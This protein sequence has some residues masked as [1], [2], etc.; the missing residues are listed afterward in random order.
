[1][2]TRTF[3]IIINLFTKGN[4]ELLKKIEKAWDSVGEETITSVFITDLKILFVD[5]FEEICECIYDDFSTFISS[6]S[7]INHPSENVE[8]KELDSL[9]SDLRTF[10]RKNLIINLNLHDRR[11]EG[12]KSKADFGLSFQFPVLKYDGNNFSFITY[13]K[14]MLLQCK[15]NSDKAIN[16]FGEIDFSTLKKYSINNIKNYF[17]LLFYNFEYK[18]KNKLKLK[19][20][21]YIPISRELKDEDF[22]NEI[23][24]YLRKEKNECCKDSELFMRDFINDK[25]GTKND[26]EFDFFAKID[27]IKVID[28]D[29]RFSDSDKYKL[30][31]MI[32]NLNIQ[33]NENLNKL[34]YLKL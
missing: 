29:F 19:N 28:I 30:E 11:Q 15:K 26:T 8:K 34:N 5:N 14:G 9:L 33:K 24:K 31:E 17:T 32:N 27:G 6:S 13:K 2:F 18:S 20:L 3:E 22:I 21:I 1:M 23:E 12:D 7:Y 10:Y 25:I 4:A 16:N